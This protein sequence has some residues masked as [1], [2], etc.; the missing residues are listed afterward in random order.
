MLNQATITVPGRLTRDPEL[1]FTKTGLQVAN[2]DIAY[3]ERTKDKQTQQWADGKP[4]YFRITLWGHD[5]EAA[6]DTLRKGDRVTI[7]GGFR[8]IYWTDDNGQEHSRL[9]IEPV[10]EIG[11]TPTTSHAPTTPNEAPNPDPWAT[12]PGNPPF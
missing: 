4:E 5:A 1:R 12:D 11:K 8:M 3:T 7:T 9:G 6:A 10:A 2:F